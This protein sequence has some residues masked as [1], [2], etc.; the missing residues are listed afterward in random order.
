MA[1]VIASVFPYSAWLG[2]ATVPEA[3]TAALALVALASLATQQAHVRTLAAA[4]LFCA[5]L[6]RYEAWPVAAVFVIVTIH[7]AWRKRKPG[8][9]AAVA[10]A[11]VGPIVWFIHGAI[12]HGHPLF[13][14]ARVA[15]YSEAIAQHA[16]PWWSR[17]FRYPLAVLRCEPELSI[18]A[19]LLLALGLR[20]GWRPSTAWLRLGAGFAAVITFLMLGDLR[21]SAATHHPERALLVIWFGLA[22]LVAKLLPKVFQATATRKRSL[23]LLGAA[24]LLSVFMVRPWFA[25]RDGFIDREAYLRFGAEAAKRTG[26][27]TLLID[28]PDFGFYAII[29]GAEDPYRALPLQT[30]DPRKIT[31]NDFSSPEKLAKTMGHRQAVWL[32]TTEPAHHKIANSWGRL[33]LHAPQLRL[34]RASE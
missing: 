16:P 3:W 27:E 4:G 26:E 5:T 14:V 11:G 15:A 23:S 32:V 8:L 33:E 1:S 13:F 20:Q 7:D 6:S 31:S 9:F 10:L 29:A 19:F 24:L 28:T 34:W 30:R 25:R 2:V 17:L 21:G 22:L 18:S 12:H